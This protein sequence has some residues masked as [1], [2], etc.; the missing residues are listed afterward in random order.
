MAIL[1]EEEAYRYHKEHIEHQYVKHQ[2][3]EYLRGQIP[4]QFRFV[5]SYIFD[6]FSFLTDLLVNDRGVH[7]LEV[8]RLTVEQRGHLEDYKY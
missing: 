2:P 5:L 6:F 7:G 8:D 3:V 4:A 1:A